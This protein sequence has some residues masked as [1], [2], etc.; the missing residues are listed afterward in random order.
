[1]CIACAS[2]I[3]CIINLIC[4]LIWNIIIVA[5]LISYS[6]CAFC[7]KNKICMTFSESDILHKSCDGQDWK[8]KQCIGKIAMCICYSIS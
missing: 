1:M 4:K 5:F 8:Y 7:E 3:F 6:Q 2:Y